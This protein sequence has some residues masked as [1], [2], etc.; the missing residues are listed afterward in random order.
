MEPKFK[1]V[2]DTNILISSLWGGNPGRIIELWDE[3]L[4]LLVA[5]FP[6]LDE[7]FSIFN[8]FNLTEEDIE[9]ITIIFSNP[10]K[11]RII[12]PKHKITLIKDDPDD[13]RFIECAL[14]GEVNFLISGDKHLLSVKEKIKDFEIIRVVQ[15]LKLIDK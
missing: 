11:T 12:V 15:F 7:Y 3:G 10:T 5:S 13:N 6:I 2:L 8:R 14:A 4:F 1:I 9:N